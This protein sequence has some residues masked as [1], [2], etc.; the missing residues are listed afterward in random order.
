MAHPK[1]T[2]T[3]PLP[4]IYHIFRMVVTGFLIFIILLIIITIS[5]IAIFD[6]HYKGKIYPNVTVGNVY[7]GGQ[8]QSDIKNYWMNK[9]S[10][11]EKAT[12]EFKFGD[13]VATASGS[14]LDLGYDSDL[15]ALQAY[16]IGRSGNILTD[17]NS[18]LLTKSINLSP[19]FHWKSDVLDQILE[20]MSNNINIPATD[21]L[22]AFKNGRVTSFKP[23]SDGRILN[24]D[25]TK[26][27]F[28]E[29]ITTVPHV[30]TSSFTI[31][32]AVDIVKP[33]V[34][35]N[36]ANSYGIKELIGRGYSEFAGSINGRIHN[37]AL[38]ADRF[39]GVLIPPGTII[40]FNQTLG[41]VSAATGYQQA[42][43]IKNGR[44]VLGDGG[45]VCQVSTTLFRAAMDAGLPILERHAHDYRVHYYEE[46]GFKP[47]VDATVF[48]PSADFK[49]QNDTENYILIQ[50]KTDLDKL[51][52]EFDLYGTSDGR[53]SLL[54]NYKLWDITPPPP[55]LYQDDPTLKVGVVKQVDFT[56]W[57]A[58][59]SFDYKVTRENE[60]LQNTTFVSNYRPWQAIYLR[61][62]MP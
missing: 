57:G 4:K 35:T 18:R 48:D 24:L 20:N 59:A 7:F 51:T 1:V 30:A 46:G 37:V 25:K 54:S 40:S 29:T 19:L 47:G 52:L 9:N 8:T 13:M 6:Y 14:D 43:I 16:L 26:K 53:K 17:I 61:G 41:D 21:A 27:K 60:T 10:P 62:T 44:T 38:A 28:V 33:N 50:T 11:F 12:F 23:S 56:A 42:Y 34:T 22:F 36:K 45:G 2:P 49:I 15:S 31:N 58:K 3:K 5:G 55:D 39:N 32:L